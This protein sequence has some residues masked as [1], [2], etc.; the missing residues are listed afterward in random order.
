V[1]V[2][3]HTRTG[4]LTA[5]LEP[6]RNYEVLVVPDTEFAPIVVHGRPAEIINSNLFVLDPGISVSG[7]VSSSKGP[8]NGARVLLRDG[9][10]PSTTG[11][12]D[13]GRYDLRV[14]N[15]NRFA[16][17]VIP[18]P[19]SGLPEARLAAGSGLAIYDFPPGPRT[20]DFSWSAIDTATLDLT[21][22]DSAGAAVKSAVRVRLVSDDAAFPDVGTLTLKVASPTEPEQSYSYHP[23]GFFQVEKLSDARGFISFANLPRGKY[24]AIFTPTDG[25]AAVTNASFDVSAARVTTSARLAR[26]VAVSGQLLPVDRTQGATLVALDPEADPTLAPPSAIIGADGGY[27]L[28]LDPGRSYQLVLQA[29]PA[30]GLPRTLLRSMVGPSKDMMREALTVGGA[31]PVS[32]RITGAAVAGVLVEAYCM[33]QPPS[34]IDPAAPDVTR[35]RPIAETISDQDGNYRLLVPDPS[36]TY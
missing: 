29:E 20:L 16:A 27:V 1:L 9:P 28:H 17:V 14:R 15:G 30:N 12:V 11:T 21:V 6:S 13:G 7:Q 36:I 2:E 4:A 8:A 26:K 31:V 18:P 24:N 25:S 35:V 19:D 34:C 3:G 22:L 23:S 5:H 32:G 33:G 10:V